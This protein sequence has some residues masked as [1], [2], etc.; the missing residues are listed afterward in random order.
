MRF[1]S[2]NTPQFR[3]HALEHLALSS[4]VPFFL[5]WTQDTP[6]RKTALDTPTFGCVHTSS[7]EQIHMYIAFSVSA[8]SR[9][10]CWIRYNG[11][12]QNVFTIACCWYIMYI[13]GCATVFTAH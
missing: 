8:Y 3:A 2:L 11:S 9:C 7:G 10:E 6:L 1:G 4:V 13:C 12:R 5:L